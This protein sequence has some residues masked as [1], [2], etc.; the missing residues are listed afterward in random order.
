VQLGELYLSQNQRDLA[1]VEFRGTISD[2]K[3]A[4]GYQRRR[5]RSWVRKAK[6]LLA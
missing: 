6:K 2:D 5:D 3:H 4:P 1:D